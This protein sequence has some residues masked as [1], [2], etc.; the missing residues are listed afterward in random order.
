MSWLAKCA[1]IPAMATDDSSTAAITAAPAGM[2]MVRWYESRSVSRATAFKL[3]TLAGLELGRMRVPEIRTPVAWLE[4]HQLEVMDH[5][6]KELANGATLALLKARMGG[7]LVPL[8][9]AGEPEP[10]PELEPAQADL[11]QE[12]EPPR[13]GSIQPAGADAHEALEARVRTGR[14][15]M[16]T[17]LPLS[18]NEVAWLLQARPGAAV[19]QRGGVIARRQARN[20]WTLEPAPGSSHLE[21]A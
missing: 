12:L 8:E 13:A 16:E 15:A 3:A 5:L 14:L 6:A 4:E 9:P 10:E 7:A 17:R 20:V 19:V 2:T 21:P 11:S 18:T 1:T